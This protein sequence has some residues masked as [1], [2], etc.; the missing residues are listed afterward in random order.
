MAKLI[1]SANLTPNT[2]L[3]SMK[4]YLQKYKELTPMNFNL[5]VAEV[6][7]GVSTPDG[8]GS[9]YGT[10]GMKGQKKSKG[11]ISMKDGSMVK[12]SMKENKVTGKQTKAKK[13][14]LNLSVLNP[15]VNRQKKYLEVYSTP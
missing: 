2:D 11:Q 3:G 8:T 4:R 6:Q 15:G 13:L 7:K 1:G 5:D 9:Q 12:E 14:T 10:I